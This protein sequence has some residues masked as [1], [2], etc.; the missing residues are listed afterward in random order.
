MPMSNKLEDRARP[1]GVW[2][3]IHPPIAL[4]VS[5]I[6][7][8]LELH[9]HGHAVLRTKGQSARGY[10]CRG[11]VAKRENMQ[12]ECKS[13]GTGR[14][15]LLWLCT[16]T[17]INLNYNQ[18]YEV[19]IQAVRFN[20]MLFSSISGDPCRNYGPF[21]SPFFAMCS[22]QKLYL[23]L[24]TY[25]MHCI[26]LYWLLVLGYVHKNYIVSSSRDTDRYVQGMW[27]TNTFDYKDNNS[28]KLYIGTASRLTQPHFL[29]V[30]FI[31][32]HF[33]NIWFLLPIQ[34]RHWIKRTPPVYQ[35]DH[36]LSRNLLLII[37]HLMALVMVLKKPWFYS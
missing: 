34:N 33:N 6:W 32:F 25:G 27:K 26:N 37:F 28:C 31:H 8:K 23:W 5:P 18:A 10:V 3:Y 22:Q 21:Y 13:I 7:I 36:S 35:G 2:H 29:P 11:N 16:P 15:L 4:T 12:I 14:F 17:S 1:S 24:H 30:T 20:L 19:N 9:K